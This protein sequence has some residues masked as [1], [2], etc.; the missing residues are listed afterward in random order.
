MQVPDIHNDF[1]YY[2]MI[3][4][5]VMLGVCILAALIRLVRGPG[6]P[7][8]VIA[9]D[10]MGFFVIGII[11]V[12]AIANDRSVILAVALVMALVLFLGTAAFAWFVEQRARP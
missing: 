8:R 9:L 10:L 3:A 1:L 12:Y 7:D 6:L 11:G 4:C 2:T 5:G